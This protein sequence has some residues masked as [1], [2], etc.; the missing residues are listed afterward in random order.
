MAGCTMGITLS[1]LKVHGTG[2]AGCNARGRMPV[3][4][5]QLLI[6]QQADS[7]YPVKLWETP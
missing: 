6:N 7:N 4:A 3:Y 2:F 5:R 1:Q